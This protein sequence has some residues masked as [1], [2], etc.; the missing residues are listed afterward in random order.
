[1]LWVN[2]IMDTLGGL[3]FAGEPPLREY[4]THPPKAND[5]KIL[6]PQMMRGILLTGAF[7]VAL[8]ISFLKI[9]AI[10]DFLAYPYDDAYL[11]T[12]FFALFIFA[13]IFNC[14]NA[15]T[16]RVNL[17]AH[18]AKN[19]PFMLIMLLISAI[20]VVLIYTG[21][22]FFRTVPLTVR[23]LLLTIA[24]AATVIPVDIARKIACK[25]RDRRAGNN[26]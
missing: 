18:L 15:R 20:Q 12:A 3:A 24:L 6:T 8:A 9:P 11:M 17:T 19:R 23:D 7:T 26:L 25:R 21:G 16:A 1:M 2:I 14:F 10:H 22:T 4:M 5:E 13:G